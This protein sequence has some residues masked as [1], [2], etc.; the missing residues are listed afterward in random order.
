MDP[1]NFVDTMLMNKLIITERKPSKDKTKD[2][3]QE[4]CLTTTNLNSVRS[5]IDAEQL[6]KIEKLEKNDETDLP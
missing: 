5:M 2:K 3:K 4:K 1:V 6:E